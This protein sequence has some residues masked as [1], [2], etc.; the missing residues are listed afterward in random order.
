MEL[1]LSD[2]PQPTITFSPAEVS[3]IKMGGADLIKLMVEK[4]VK[5]SMNDLKMFLQWGRVRE[6]KYLA[7][8]HNFEFTP[9][10][11]QYCHSPEALAELK[12]IQ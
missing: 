11:L 2:G 8:S 5:Y 6:A 9:D 4:G 12:K 10:V 1:T 3:T 7:Q